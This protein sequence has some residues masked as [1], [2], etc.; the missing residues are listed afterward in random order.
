MSRTNQFLDMECRGGREGG[1]GIGP[2]QNGVG[3]WSASMVG[4]GREE[5]RLHEGRGFGLAVL[6]FVCVYAAG[7]DII[8][9]GE[10]GPCAIR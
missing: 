1:M 10:M 5:G 3:G 7:C 9:V 2:L 4:D 8:W 6:G